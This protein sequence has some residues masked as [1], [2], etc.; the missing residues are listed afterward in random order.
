MPAPLA[1]DS[2]SLLVSA[3][4][5]IVVVL[6]SQV[7]QNRREN[8]KEKKHLVDLDLG[9]R[10]SMKRHYLTEKQEASLESVRIKNVS[11][12]CNTVLLKLIH[13]FTSSKNAWI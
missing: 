11:M 5:F 4:L 13:F 8:D 12:F 2:S 3:G 7:V 10:Y 9:H 6:T 1:S